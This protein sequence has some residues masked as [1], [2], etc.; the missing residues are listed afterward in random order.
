MNPTHIHLLITHLPIF[1]SM[2]G[3]LVLGYGIWAKSDPTKVAA[4]L[5]FIIAALGGTIA[6]LT[7][8]PAEESVEHITGVSK[9][10]IEEHEESASFT[11]VSLII[12]GVVSI[13]GIFVIKKKSGSERTVAL[14]TFIISL[15]AFSLAARTGYLGGQIRHQT[16]INN[17][18]GEEPQTGGTPAGR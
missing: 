2:L 3:A 6:Y 5:I 14:A 18:A 8:E 12:T 11:L 7:G 10:D 15:I 17:P 4:Y 13:G 16:E 1:G 9:D